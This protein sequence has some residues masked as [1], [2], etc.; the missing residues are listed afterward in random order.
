MAI[1]CSV[2][3]QWIEATG[4]VHSYPSKSKNYD[5]HI[6]YVNSEDAVYRYQS[7]TLAAHQR[8]S[9]DDYKKQE[10]SSDQD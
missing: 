2:C 8:V 9:F 10:F 1:R 3:E 6:P 4:S 7:A 5:E